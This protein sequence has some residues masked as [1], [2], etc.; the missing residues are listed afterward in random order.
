MPFGEQFDPLSCHSGC[1]SGETN[2]LYIDNLTSGD[3]IE[4]HLNGQRLSEG[5][6]NEVDLISYWNK[7]WRKDGGRFLNGTIIFES[8]PLVEGRN[9]LEVRLVKHPGNLAVPLKLALVEAAIKYQASR[10]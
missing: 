6:R 2:R 10:G 1:K 3:E 9:L 7:G 4:V 5:H 8:P